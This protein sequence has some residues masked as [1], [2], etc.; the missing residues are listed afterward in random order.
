[1]FV[2]PAE[3]VD[4]E[5]S[6]QKRQLKN[7]TSRHAIARLGPSVVFADIAMNPLPFFQDSPYNTSDVEITGFHGFGSK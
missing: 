7:L 4:D 6:I 3:L 5:L 2:I 1:V